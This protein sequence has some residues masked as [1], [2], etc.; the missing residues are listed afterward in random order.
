[1]CRL[2]LACF[3]GYRNQTLYCCLPERRTA[4]L[5]ILPKE[6][7]WFPLC[8]PLMSYWNVLQRQTEFL[9]VWWVTTRRWSYGIAF[10]GRE[11]HSPMGDRGETCGFTG[12][13][14]FRPDTSDS[15]CTGNTDAWFII[16][17]T[18][19]NLFQIGSETADDI[20]DLYIDNIYVLGTLE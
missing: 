3:P 17:D 18:N 5:W 8:F 15:E 12:T 1:M 14:T 10:S 20:Q 9:V 13:I 4:I 7:D 16:G 2:L 19:C 6:K 11:E